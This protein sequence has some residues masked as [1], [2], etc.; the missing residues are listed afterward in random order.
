MTPDKEL[1]YQARISTLLE[2]LNRHGVS[3]VGD[4]HSALDE[5]VREEKR[6]WVEAMAEKF[7]LLPKIDSFRKMLVRE[8]YPADLIESELRRMAEELK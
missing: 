3:V 1:Q 7:S 8:G 2:L 5:Y 4:D 6:K